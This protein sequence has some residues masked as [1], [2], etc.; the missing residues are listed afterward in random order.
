MLKHIRAINVSQ[1]IIEI[2]VRG[3]KPL[4]QKRLTT[5]LKP[6]LNE[7]SENFNMGHKKAKKKKAS[8]PIKIPLET[9]QRP[10]TNFSF[11]KGK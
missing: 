7:I 10:T 4:P 8:N 3:K 11:A 1:L 5:G 6:Q 2:Q 9:S